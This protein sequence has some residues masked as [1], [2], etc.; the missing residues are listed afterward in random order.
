MIS[1]G[2]GWCI[3]GNGL[4]SPLCRETGVCRH[5]GGPIKTPT[6][7]PPFLWNPS[8]RMCFSGLKEYQEALNCSPMMPRDASLPDRDQWSLLTF[9][10][11]DF[12]GCRFSKTHAINISMDR[13]FVRFA[14]S[15]RA[16]KALIK[17]VYAYIYV[18]TICTCIHIGDIYN[19]TKNLE[20][21]WPNQDIL[22]HHN[23][24]GWIVFHFF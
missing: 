4:L 22:R 13:N 6:P 16:R 2:S 11:G 9:Q 19:K 23:S 5:N 15:Q 21:A 1:V 10:S 20:N 3:V 18:C 8:I 12:R 24:N 17:N 7:S 14:H